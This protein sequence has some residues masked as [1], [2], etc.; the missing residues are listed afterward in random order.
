MGITAG[1][2]TGPSKHTISGW[3]VMRGSS[4]LESTQQH[5]GGHVTAELVQLFPTDNVVPIAPW[6]KHSAT[7]KEA[8]RKIQAKTPS[9]RDKVYSVLKYRAMTDEELS[10]TLGMNPSTCRPRRIE[11]VGMGLVETVGISVTKSGRRA[12]VWRATTEST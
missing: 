8:S 1:S 6:Q 7:S 9:L 11:L 3:P 12:Q 5:Q 10:D 2:K 4:E